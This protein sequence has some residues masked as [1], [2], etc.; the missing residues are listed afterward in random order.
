MLCL[1]GVV[2]IQSDVS[3]SPWWLLQIDNLAITRL[4]TNAQ[5]Y[6][7]DSRGSA[8]W[9]PTELM[10]TRRNR[11]CEKVGDKSSIGGDDV[12]RS[13]IGRPLNDQCVVNFLMHLLVC[14]M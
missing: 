6:Q 9:T 12:S 10:V 13:N 4:G 1:V 2:E 11:S 7:I 8:S 5:F 3:G 14:R